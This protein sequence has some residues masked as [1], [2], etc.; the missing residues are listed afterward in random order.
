[1]TPLN[2]SVLDSE[3]TSIRNNILRM[4]SI[5]DDAIEKS[6]LALKT[7]D[8]DLAGQIIAGDELVNKIRYD[9]EQES[10]LCI[11]TQQP[12]AIDLR[13]IIAGIHLAVELERIGDHAAGIAKLVR[14]LESEDE[15]DSL[16]KLPKMANRARRMVE[17][18]IRAFIDHDVSLAEKMISRDD[19]LD[20][21]YRLLVQ[22]MFEEMATDQDVARRATFLLWAGHNLERVGDRA[23]NIAERVIFMVT[24]KFVEPRVEEDDE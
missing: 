23:T 18:G 6:I 9:I 13:T 16:H 17:E 11:A 7:L 20:K 24:G 4:A 5:V 21:H 12:A 22:E 2:R 14:R 1:M 15:I 19:K 3:I 10:H 8:T